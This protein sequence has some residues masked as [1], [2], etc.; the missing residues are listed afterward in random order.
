[1]I[2]LTYTDRCVP[3]S[4][5]LSETQVWKRVSAVIKLKCISQKHH[6]SHV[7]RKLTEQSFAVPVIFN[8]LPFRNEPNKLHNINIDKPIYLHVYG[9]RRAF[10]LSFVKEDIPNIEKW[11]DQKELCD[12]L[13]ILRGCC[14]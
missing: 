7:N 13:D 14:G 5:Y 4:F 12:L 11:F 2:R 1:M 6:L 9:L 10:Y 3:S 8:C